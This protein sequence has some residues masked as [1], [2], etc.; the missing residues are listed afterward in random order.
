MNLNPKL[1]GLAIGLAVGLLL[2]LVGWRVVL[3]LLAFAL[4]GYLIGGYLESREDITR[5]LYELLTRIF[6]Q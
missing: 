1:L 6:H 3:I 2:V 4:V 5:R